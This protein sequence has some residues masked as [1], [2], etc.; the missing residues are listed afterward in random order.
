MTTIRQKMKS[1]KDNLEHLQQKCVYIINCSCGEQYIRETGKSVNIGLKEN[2][3]D[4]RRERTRSSALAE[5]ARKT[6]HHICLENTKVIEN[7]KHYYKHKVREALEV[8][9]HSHNLNMDGGLEIS[10]NW[11][12]ILTHG[13]N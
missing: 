5:H 12:S 9:K 13:L 7:E 4:I 6:N 3:V 10:R 1:V 11:T 8:I 2:S